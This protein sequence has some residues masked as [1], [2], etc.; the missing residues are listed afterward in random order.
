MYTASN[1]SFVQSVVRDAIKKNRRKNWPR[2]ILGARIAVHTAGISHNQ[3]I[4]AV[5]LDRL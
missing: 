4:L 2:E 5:T 1:P 3:F